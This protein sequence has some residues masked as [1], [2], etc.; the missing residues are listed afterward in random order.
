VTR[1][2]RIRSGVAVV[3]AAFVSAAISVA[4]LPGATAANM[5]PASAPA[6]VSG[7]AAGVEGWGFDATGELGDG[8]LGTATAPV[9]V[10]GLSRVTAVSA[11]GH[12]SLALLA[13]GTVEA[14][15][16]NNVGQ[17][18]DGSTSPLSTTPVPVEGLS[19]VVAV[20][21]GDGHSLAL[22]SNGTVMAWGENTDGQLGNGVRSSFS[23]VPVAVAG[24]SGVVAVAAGN[25]D[26]YAVLASGALMAWGNN[27]YGELGVGKCCDVF[28]SP[29][30]VKGISGV[31]KVASAGTHTVALLSSGTVMTWGYGAAGNGSN[32]ANYVPVAVPGLAD[33]RAVTAGD[34]F[35]LALLSSGT[36]VGWGSDQSGELGIPFTGIG[37]SL[38]PITVPGLSGITAI[39]SGSEFSLAVTSTGSVFGWG[40]NTFGQMLGVSSGAQVDPPVALPGVS[41]VETASAGGLH[42]LV[43]TTAPIGRTPPGPSSYELGAIPGDVGPISALS[44]SNAWGLN[45][46]DAE[47][48]N[49]KAWT[50]T[51]LVAPAGG[52]GSFNEIYAATQTDVWVVG[53]IEEAA[54]NKQSLIENWN[55]KTW[56]IVP[57]P[58][59]FPESQFGYDSLSAVSGSGPDDIWAVGYDFPDSDTGHIVPL[60]AHYNGTTWTAVSP[61]RLQGDVQMS[62]VAD[63]SPTDVW[64]VGADVFPPLS[65]PG[66]LAVALHYNGRAWKA[67]KV[68]AIGDKWEDNLPTAVTIAAP[69]DV[70]IAENTVNTHTDGGYFSY[71]LNYNGTGF[72]VTP[73]PAPDGPDITVGTVLFGITSLGTDDIYTDGVATYYSDGSQT[74]LT[75]H[76]N[77]T[78]WSQLP[79]PQPDDLQPLGENPH[80]FLINIASAPGGTVFETG[81]GGRGLPDGGGLTLETTDG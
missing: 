34:V 44:A 17:L 65:H 52:T 57:S 30:A 40:D 62:A 59:P 9:D 22:L 2:L 29:V 81:Y 35:D 13:N 58:N 77:G 10:E 14:W 50:R 51:T 49:G 1:R 12:H 5:R 64:A 20:S 6:E 61:P 4:A 69:D 60:L 24:L 54:G 23:D 8:M 31:V 70:W 42:A 76:Y 32:N 75:Y 47:H 68:P 27:N 46:P 53:T 72:T 28:D 43:T 79:G 33:V 56:T 38:L 63:A 39:S 67:V 7:V 78:A 37:L 3:A 71:L 16:Q 48:W 15:G 36:V 26:S 41:G 80:D 21:A 11:G 55:G 25:E 19:G 18:G 73:A 66:A 74:T 45:D